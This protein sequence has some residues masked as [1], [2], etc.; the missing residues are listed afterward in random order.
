MKNQLIKEIA[1]KLDEVAK[2]VHLKRKKIKEEIKLLLFK[3]DNDVSELQKRK[4]YLEKE[5]SI[6]SR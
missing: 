1:S 2:F 3:L 6:L 4:T 5:N